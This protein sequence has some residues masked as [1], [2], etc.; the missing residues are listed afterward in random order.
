M[1][2]KPF[3]VCRMLSG[4]MIVSILFSTYC[5]YWALGDDCLA[6]PPAMQIATDP[7]HQSFGGSE[8]P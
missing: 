1:S 6:D 3:I 8:G 5:A 7:P 2:F 4:R